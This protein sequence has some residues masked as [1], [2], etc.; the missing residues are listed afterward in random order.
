MK[1]GYILGKLTRKVYFR[2]S[3]YKV[4]KVYF[5]DPKKYNLTYFTENYDVSQSDKVMGK[6]KR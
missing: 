2:K 3:T 6:S 1:T 5:I 4:Y